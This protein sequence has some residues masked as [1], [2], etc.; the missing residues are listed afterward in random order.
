MTT[1][2]KQRRNKME[3][4]QN[5]TWGVAINGFCKF[6]APEIACDDCN[7]LNR[8]YDVKTVKCLISDKLRILTVCDEC[9]SKR[10]VIE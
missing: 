5:M 9:R 1:L 10:T 4:V 3:K 7:T 6:E 8:E 2:K